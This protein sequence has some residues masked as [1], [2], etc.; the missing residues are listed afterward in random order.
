V[1]ILAGVALVALAGLLAVA[2]A[3]WFLRSGGGSRVAAAIGGRDPLVARL[4]EHPFAGGPLP[5]WQL[6]VAPS[7]DD[8]VTREP[9]QTAVIH[10]VSGRLQGGSPADLR[11]AVFADAAA[12]QRSYADGIRELARAGTVVH[13]PGLEGLCVGDAERVSLCRGIAGRTVVFAL[14]L[15]G[16]PT[17]DAVAAMQSLVDHLASLE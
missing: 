1:P 6:P 16:A 17:G 9:G 15:E 5:G 12:A 4:L 3:V 14:F 8:G 11:L 10:L 2:A 7:L 13:L